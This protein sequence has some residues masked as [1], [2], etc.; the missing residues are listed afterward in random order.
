M[1]RIVIGIS[2][3]SG[4]IYG[5]R[6]MEAIEGRVES[7]LIITRAAR[8]NISLET[9]YQLGQVHSLA[10][11]VHE[12]DDLAAPLSSGSFRTDGMVII[13]CSIKSLSAVANSYTE[14]LMTRA[15]DV[16]LKEKRRLVLVVREFPLHTGHLRLMVR[17]SEI[18]ATISPPVPAFY[19][20]P[21]TVDD[22]INQ[23]IGKILDLFG[24]EHTFF[25]R[26][27]GRSLQ[28]ET[29]SQDHKKIDDL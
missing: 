10:S 27:Q 14:N 25:K 22:V 6:M 15:A 12:I 28:K 8:E 16:T 1:K 20:R 26:W 5:I 21:K 19:Q 24:I 9:S 23:T 18:G 2:G 17:A 4:A 29:R 7:H 3:A 13:P 11:F